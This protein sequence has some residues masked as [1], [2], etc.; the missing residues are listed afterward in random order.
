MLGSGSPDDGVVDDQHVL[1]SELQVDGIQFPPDG[2]LAQRLPGHDKRAPDITVLDETFAILYVQVI[3]K[4]QSR[5][6]ACIRHRDDNV[7]VVIG[8]LTQNL[9]GQRLA[10]AKSRLVHR[11]VIEQRVGPGEIYKFKDTGR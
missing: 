6:A 2:L 4:R 10:H 5:G 9:P 8:A 1:F 11:Y 7:D 3:G